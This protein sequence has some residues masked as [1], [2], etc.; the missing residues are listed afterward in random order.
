LPQANPIELVLMLYDGA[1][2]AIRLAAGH[3]KSRPHADKGAA[4]S[5]AISIVD[6]GLK[7][8]LD[9]TWAGEIAGPIAL[10]VRIHDDASAAGKPA[11][12]RARA[13]MKFCDCSPTCAPLGAVG[14]QGAVR[15]R[16]PLQRPCKPHR[17]ASTRGADL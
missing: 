6:N 8:S 9:H 16:C 12:R 3:L 13:G 2:V 10:A 17:R 11:Q 15:T 14:A 1:L 4:L 5:K 7:A